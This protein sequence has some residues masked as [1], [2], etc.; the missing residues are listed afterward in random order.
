MY[1]ANKLNRAYFKYIE[2]LKKENKKRG[3]N[4]KKK[5]QKQLDLFETPKR[6]G[7]NMVLLLVNNGIKRKNMTEHSGTW[8][9]QTLTD[10]RGNMEKRKNQ[11]CS[12]LSEKN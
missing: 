3:K 12:V 10:L 7:K 5:N 1:L 6:N 11:I 2:S 8:N 4:G 9:R